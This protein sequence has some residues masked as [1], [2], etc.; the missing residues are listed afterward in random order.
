MIKT[1]V[2]FRVEKSMELKMADFNLVEFIMP[3][4]DKIAVL[5]TLLI[6]STP[7]FLTTFHGGSGATSYSFTQLGFP[8]AAYALFEESGL[9]TGAELNN[10]N[11]LLV[12]GFVVDLIFWYVIACLVLYAYGLFTGKGKLGEVQ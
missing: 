12:I 11:K 1:K 2:N 5:I 8:M 6:I 7:L 9:I 3:K 4:A 10:L